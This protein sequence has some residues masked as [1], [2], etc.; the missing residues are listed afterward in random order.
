MEGRGE[1]VQTVLDE[2][3]T[4]ANIR[5]RRIWETLDEKEQNALKQCLDNTPT[6]LRSLR[7]RG[8]VT[9]QG[10]FFWSSIA[11]MVERNRYHLTNFSKWLLCLNI[12]K[13]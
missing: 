6:T 11:T 13:Y 10:L 7:I 9:E 8:L 5:L 2:F 12:F 3:Q 1:S 4:E